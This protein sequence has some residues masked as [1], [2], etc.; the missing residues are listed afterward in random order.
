MS[1]QEEAQAKAVVSAN[2]WSEMVALSIDYH[3][4][5]VGTLISRV[6]IKTWDLIPTERE[7]KCPNCA[8]RGMSCHYPIKGSDRTMKCRRCKLS[9]RPCPGPRKRNVSTAADEDEEADE[10]DEELTPSPSESEDDEA[11]PPPP[12]PQR[13]KTM[14]RRSNYGWRPQA[15]QPHVTS[16]PSS[17][18]RM[19]RTASAGKE[20]L[21]ALPMDPRKRLPSGGLP[22][23][24]P[25]KQGEK[26]KEVAVDLAELENDIN[27]GAVFTSTPFLSMASSNAV[28]NATTS[29]VATPK[30]Q[31][32]YTS[33]QATASAPRTESSSPREEFP[34]YRLPTPSPQRTKHQSLPPSSQAA[35]SISMSGPPPTQP[36]VPPSSGSTVASPHSQAMDM[37]DSS[38]RIPDPPQWHSR[39]S[40]GQSTAQERQPSLFSE[41]YMS[42]I[43]SMAESRMLDR[44]ERELDR[45]ERDLE[46][47]ERE[48]EKLHAAKDGWEV[49]ERGLMEENR[50]LKE[51]GD[52]LK[53]RVKELEDLQDGAR[54]EEDSLRDRLKVFLQ[55]KE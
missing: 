4:P 40:S 15:V 51:E 1:E 52:A 30:D 26:G 37:D 20:P 47:K 46:R 36:V 21:V 39:P 45:K 29:Q 16:S 32:P 27:Q 54:R 12:P 22:P 25:V 18:R 2:D 34:Q 13:L 43:A 7:E 17:E 24:S 6:N 44:L 31:T 50:R 11:P 8:P 9:H 38:F 35:S 55:L 19:T 49:R 23:K 28:P 48:I 41:R 42:P 14:A 10:D 5:L 33:T 3:A 53:R